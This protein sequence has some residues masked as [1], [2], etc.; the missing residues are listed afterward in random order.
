MRERVKKI[1]EHIFDGR[2][3]FQ[4]IAYETRY[5]LRVGEEQHNTH[6]TSFSLCVPI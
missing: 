2:N 5:Q 6:K 1:E 3:E 4:P